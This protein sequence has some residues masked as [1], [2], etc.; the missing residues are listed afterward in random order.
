MC[1]TL[2]LAT[3]TKPLN[4]I[5]LNY[6]RKRK[7]VRTL[8]ENGC[9]T[10]SIIKNLIVSQQSKYRPRRQETHTL[11]RIDNLSGALKRYA[12]ISIY[13][14]NHIEDNTSNE[15]RNQNL[16]WCYREPIIKWIIVNSEHKQHLTNLNVRSEWNNCVYFSDSSKI[17]TR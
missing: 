6:K 8:G 10:Q 1:E 4:D 9:F 3:S 12:K 17:Y 5:N 7:L 14:S 13:S 11:T 2:M 15:F 16:N